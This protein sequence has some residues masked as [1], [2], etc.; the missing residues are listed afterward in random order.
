MC[1]A[2]EE[3]GAAFQQQF[4]PLSPLPPPPHRSRFAAGHSLRATAADGDGAGHSES[5][6][7]AGGHA[8]AEGASRMEALTNGGAAD[9]SHE[10]GVAGAGSGI[11]SS[12]DDDGE[13]DNKEP[14][15]V[16]YLSP[17]L[18]TVRRLYLRLPAANCGGFSQGWGMYPPIV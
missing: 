18:F 10:N 1:T 6:A 15:V 3:W 9:H 13:G 14:L 11:G 12:D 5:A 17:D 2:H 16:G 8:A 7:A 4:Q